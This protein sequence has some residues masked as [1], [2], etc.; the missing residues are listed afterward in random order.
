MRILIIEEDARLTM[1]L[2]AVITY[3]G[4]NAYVSMDTK[5]SLQLAAS[6]IYDAVILNNSF[7]GYSILLRLREKEV[8]VP[9]IMLTDKSG[10]TLA[11]DSDK[12]A[13]YYL[14][15]PLESSGLLTC[16]QAILHGQGS[17]ASVTLNFADLKLAPSAYKLY[18]KSNVI[19]LSAKELDVMQILIVNG[20]Q[21]L[22]K[23]A[24]LLKIWGYERDISENNVE[25]YISFLRKKL[26]RLES[27]VHIS[28][29][30]KVGYRL[31]A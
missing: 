25:A 15:K 13:D 2:S 27:S 22:S 9:L 30:R 18:C 12:R 24:L 14:I 29:V 10:M 3:A 8:S 7:Q 11:G 16:I 4:H 26:L 17:S 21:Y 23:E 6:G 5:K 1:N 19:S 28:V 31:E 20:G